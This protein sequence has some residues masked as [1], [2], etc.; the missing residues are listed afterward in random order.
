[1]ARFTWLMAVLGTLV[2]GCS[3]SGS[4]ADDP[5]P[6]PPP[7]PPPPT[8]SVS[9]HVGGMIG[10]LTLE[11]N[12]RSDLTVSNNGGFAFAGLATGTTYAIT[13]ATPPANQSC[14]VSNGTGT[15]GSADITNVDVSCSTIRTSPSGSLDSTFGS[16]GKV[17]TAFGGKNTAMAVQSDGKILM[18]GGS[19]FDFLLAR[20]NADGSLDASFGVG[21]LVTTDIGGFTQEEARAVAVQDDGKIVVAGNV[22]VS[23]VRGGSLF[24]EFTF[25]LVRYNSDG[26]LDNSFGFG[27]T[28]K[29]KS[30]VV[31]RAFAV[32]VLNNPGVSDDKIL[33]AGD[34]TLTANEDNFR[35]ARFNADGSLDTTFGNSGSV[36]TDV[37]AGIDGAKNI[38]L[39]PDGKIV[40]SGA[41]S[42][43]S[44]TAVER[45][46][47][48]GGPD[49]S[50]GTFGSVEIAGAF[51]GEGL[52][53][54]G[55]GKLL[56]VG[57]KQ[58]GV[59]NANVTQFEV[60]RLNVDGSVDDKFGS[61]GTVNAA[62][63]TLDSAQSVA[64]QRDGRILVSGSAD[65][66]QFGVARYND[67]GTLDA[68]FAASGKLTVNFFSLETSAETVAV[69]PDDKILLGG[70]ASAGGPPGYALARI[71][72]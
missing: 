28:G 57:S 55:D 47:A 23:E 19:I 21:G 6:P 48:N 12:G 4:P 66:F 14:T 2:A 50:F 62:F 63:G 9:G 17:T 31:G 35:L 41:F 56:L 22:R 32:A 69:L 72:P 27:G 3:G 7:T 30:T 60:R 26:S 38:V 18:A 45:Y 43:S 64:V 11:N 1:M 46:T 39:Q 29:V 49:G 15:V 37:T 24:D 71:N 61:G 10:S 53:L 13:V 59:G 40:L 67:D 44:G 68:G 58:V 36:V 70:F 20:Y 33:L 52:A 34:D 25:T 8:F 16:A 5:P 54:Q 65:G 42:K 51:V